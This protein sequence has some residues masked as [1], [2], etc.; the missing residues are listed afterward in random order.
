MHQKLADRVVWCVGLYSDWIGQLAVAAVARHCSNL[1]C[2]VV[3]GGV[4]GLNLAAAAM[5]VSNVENL[6]A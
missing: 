6:A 2:G 5:A 3:F 1:V 4:F